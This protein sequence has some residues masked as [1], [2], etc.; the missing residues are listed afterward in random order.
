LATQW[1][2]DFTSYG[3]TGAAA[4]ARL[5]NGIYAE[6]V[7]ASLAADPDPTAGGVM[8]MSKIAGGLGGAL[9]KVLSAPRVTTGVAARYWLSALPNASGVDSSPWLAVFGDTNNLNNVIIVPDPSGNIRAIRTDNAGALTTLATTSTPCLT[10][11]AWK[12]IEIKCT[13]DIAAGYV[14]VRVEGITVLTFTG[15]TLGTTSGALSSTQNVSLYSAQSGPTMFVKDFIIWNTTGGVNNDF[16][17][18][19]Q[20]VKIIP[21]S[22]DSLGWTA[23]T[24]TTGFNLIND[25]T[26]DDDTGY[27]TAPF[28]L[29][30]PSQFNMTDLP[31]NVS[32]VRGVMVLHRSRKT[33]GGDGNIQVSVV[34]GANVGTG[35][36][37]P[38]TTAYTYWYDVF[39]KDPSGSSWSRTLV[40][41]LKLKLNRTL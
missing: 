36:D 7:R 9:R 17:G 27:I 18:S 35:S 14:E 25:A 11:N 40:N 28:P 5:L 26:P 15:R 4:D 39:D 21:Q 8:V 22:D 10:A 23:S 2:D 3:T 34:S 6:N 20:V 31:V 32:T 13:I 12:H 33:D 38:I 1:M 29:P 24:G 37:R 16:M 41:A 30:S 19:C